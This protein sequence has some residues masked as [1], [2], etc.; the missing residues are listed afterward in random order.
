MALELVRIKGKGPSFLSLRALELLLRGYHR[1][2]DAMFL[3]EG[4]IFGFHIL[5]Q[6]HWAPFFA[7]NLKSFHG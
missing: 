7:Q 4:F 1:L 3:L 6:D 5:V 2:V